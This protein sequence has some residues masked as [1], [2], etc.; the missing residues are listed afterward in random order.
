[1][2]GGLGVGDSIGASV[3]VVVAVVDGTN[4]APVVIVSVES[5]GVALGEE[6]S[7]NVGG[8]GVF[9]GGTEEGVSVSDGVIVGVRD[10]VA[11]GSIS[12]AVVAVAVGVNVGG[13]GSSVAVKVAV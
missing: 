7:V 12:G 9:V 11:D 6:V 5:V 1:M 13:L 2:T 10:A 8:I 3:T 4:T